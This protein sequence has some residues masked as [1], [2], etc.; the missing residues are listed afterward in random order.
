MCQP[1][2]G[3][4]PTKSTISVS[5]GVH[6]YYLRFLDIDFQAQI[7]I[8][9]I[10]DTLNNEPFFKFFSDTFTNIDVASTYWLKGCSLL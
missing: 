7:L 10:P 3:F 1:S 5:D 8:K 4:F 2:Q 6:L 9:A